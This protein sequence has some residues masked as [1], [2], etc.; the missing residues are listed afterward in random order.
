[1]S[2]NKA[3]IEYNRRK[4][5]AIAVLTLNKQCEALTVSELKAIVH[6]EKRKA[7]KAVPSSKTSI[8]ERYTN[9]IF[10]ADRPLDVFLKDSMY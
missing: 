8:Q 2:K 6:W 3:I 1:M 10:R 4:E 5:E 9:T 7:D